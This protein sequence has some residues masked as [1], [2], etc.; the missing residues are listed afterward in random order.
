MK[1]NKIVALML[2]G[3]MSLSA[4]SGCSKGTGK[5]AAGSN[6]AGTET[7]GKN[8]EGA[9]AAEQTVDLEIWNV[10]DGFL[11]VK[12]DGALY[13]FYKDIIGV[14]LVSPYVEW[15]GGDHISGTVKFKNR[16]RGD[17]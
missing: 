11:E 16:F 14:G 15:N 2:A 12:K 10:N 4:L 3:A 6:T 1:C 13:N 17:A 8:A 7:A 9:S 5:E